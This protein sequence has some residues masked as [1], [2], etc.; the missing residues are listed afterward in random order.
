MTRKAKLTCTLESSLSEL[1][2]L[3]PNTILLNITQQKQQ[4]QQHFTTTLLHAILEPK[5]L[6]LNTMLSLYEVSRKDFSDL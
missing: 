5:A 1:Q 4:Q 3:F 6:V 2:A